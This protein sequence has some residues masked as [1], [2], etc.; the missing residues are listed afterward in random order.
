MRMLPAAHSASHAV[1]ASADELKDMSDDV[2]EVDA[3]EAAARER[4]SKMAVGDRGVLERYKRVCKVV[5][6]RRL[7]KDKVDADVALQ[8]AR[9]ASTVVVDRLI[10]AA[11]LVPF[12]G[13]Y[14]ARCELFLVWTVCDASGLATAGL[15]EREGSVRWRKRVW[16]QQVRAPLQSELDDAKT[17]WLPE[18]KTKIEAIS[19]KFSENFARIGSV[20]EVGLFEAAEDYKAYAVQIKARLCCSRRCR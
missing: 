3:Q 20:G 1:R 5:D 19:E 8:Q 16:F 13:V 7:E 15:L 9:H 18:L 11:L 12:A 6:E 2:E 4:A 14:G 10:C 17:K